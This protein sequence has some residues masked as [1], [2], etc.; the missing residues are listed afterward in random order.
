MGRLRRVI[1]HRP[2]TELRRLT[3]ANKTELL[4]EDVVW[5]ERAGEEHDAFTDALRARSVEVLYL[6]DLLAQTL[7]LAAARDRV[8]TETLGRVAG[9]P[10]LG[11]ELGR[12]LTSL[13]SSELAAHLVGGI[14]FEE[15]PFRSDSLVARVSPTDAFVL[16]P[17][18]NHLFTRDASAWAFTGVSVHTM[19]KPT[20]QRE[21]LHYEL[22]YRYHPLFV[23]AEPE[24]WSGDA[25]RS[26]P[27][28]GGDILVIGDSC[29][30]VGLGERSTPAAVEAY[31]H[32]AFAAGVVDRVIVVVLPAMRSAMHLDTVLTMVDVDAFTVFPQL[33]DR[34]ETYLL[35][36]S[37]D[38]VCMRRE[39]DLFGTISQALELS[40]VRVIHSDAD[41]DTAR[42]EQWDDGNNVLALSPGVVV[43]Y[44]RNA[45]I[46]ARLRD[47]G[48]EVITIPGSE[49]ARGRG[50]PRCMT[51]PIE[52]DEL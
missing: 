22:I 41:L 11:P 29:L 52:R 46:N 16:P 50:G 42:R 38:G 39:A 26:A 14:T 12:W 7:E 8:L 40:R 19:A 30:L 33:L 27:L 15:L 36:P 37:V 17:L 35:T 31:A 20:R 49:L 24:I 32:R 9:G 10:R 13:P 34:L 6:Q 48:V 5:V 44:E 51:C 25:E 2:G 47:H 43:A 3:P 4:F 45:A 28:E 18:P 1:V 23:D 21:A